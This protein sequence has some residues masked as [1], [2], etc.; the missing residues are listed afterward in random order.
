MANWPSGS[1]L[2]MECTAPET[3]VELVA[4]GYKYNA[5]KVLWFVMTKIAASL[6][7][8]IPYKAKFP[9]Q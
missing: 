6:H 4:I 5:K 3:G 1:Y 8:G 7:A 2:V 9:D